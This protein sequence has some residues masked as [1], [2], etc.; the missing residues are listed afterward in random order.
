MTTDASGPADAAGL[1]RTEFGFPG[2]LRDRLVAASLDGSKTSTTAL[3]LGYEV[4][5]EPL[6]QVG[7][8]SVLVDSDDHPVAVLEVVH[9]RVVPLG[10]VDLSH[11]LDEG[12]GHQT[13][14]QWRAGHESFWHSPQ[15]RAV[16]GDPDFTVDDATRVVLER[17]RVVAHLPD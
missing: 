8:R 3:A 15:M 7:D 11:A 2:R 16:L 6:P 1:P 12:E 9:V 13:V 4:E 5:E 14:A 10:K 17:F